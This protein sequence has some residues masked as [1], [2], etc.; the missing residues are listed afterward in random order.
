M[1]KSDGKRDAIR[2]AAYAVMLR[3]GYDRMTLDDIAK[4][5]GISRPAIYLHYKNNGDVFRDVV[6][7]IADRQ[8]RKAA[9]Y[10]KSLSVAERLMHIVEHGIIAPWEGVSHSPHCAELMNLKSGIAAD[11]GIDWHNKLLALLASAMKGRNASIIANIVLDAV[12]GGLFRKDMPADVRKTAKVV[13]TMA[14]AMLE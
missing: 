12:D 13:A 9:A 1:K 3:Y 11:L 8:L 14:A 5:A 10:D 4:E 2:T 6:Q 7:S